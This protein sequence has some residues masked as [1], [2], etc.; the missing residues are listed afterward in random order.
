MP[1]DA[2]DAQNFDTADSVVPLT[3]PPF[4][5]TR[6]AQ[7]A[8]SGWTVWRGRSSRLFIGMSSGPEC[9]DEYCDHE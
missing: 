3:L 9:E 8:A 7:S 1:A 5:R 2:I 6:L 4:A